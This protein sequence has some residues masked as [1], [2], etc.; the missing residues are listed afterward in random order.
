MDTLD[1]QTRNTN[2]TYRALMK[3]AKDGVIVLFHDLYKTTASAAEKAIP[4]LIE[5]GYQLV[6]VSELLSFHKDGAK[7]GTTYTRVEPK[8]RVGG[9]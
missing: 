5:K 8:D 6:T 4:E 7:P 9:Q 2:K 1:W 3:G